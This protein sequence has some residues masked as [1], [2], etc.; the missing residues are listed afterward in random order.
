[1]NIKGDFNMYFTFLL[2]F[3]NNF[4]INFLHNFLIFAGKDSEFYIRI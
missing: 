4:V 2:Q 1:M 3:T